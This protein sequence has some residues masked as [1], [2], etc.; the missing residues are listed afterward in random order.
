MDNIEYNNYYEPNDIYY[1]NNYLYQ[2]QYYSF[3][4]EQDDDD[5]QFLNNIIL[6]YKRNKEIPPFVT[7]KNPKKYTLVLDLE[8]T[9]INIKISYENKAIIRPRPG[10]IEFL[11]GIISKLFKY[12][13][14]TDWKK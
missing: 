5:E 11:C 2:N 7:N 1:N 4:K 6:E 8:D 10:L 3:I 9:L 13:Y 12:N 14:S